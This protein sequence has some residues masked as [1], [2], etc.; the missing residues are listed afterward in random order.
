MSQYVTNPQ[1]QIDPNSTYQM[2]ADMGQINA[3]IGVIISS[4]ISVVMFGAGV[5]YLSKGGSFKV[6][7]DQEIQSEITSKECQIDP[8]TKANKCQYHLRYNYNG[9]IY[10]SIQQEQDI[11]IDYKTGDIVKLY[12]DPQS[13]QIAQA[14]H[15]K[16]QEVSD[17]KIGWVL[18]V[19][20]II[21]LVISWS[22]NGPQVNPEPLQPHM[23]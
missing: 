12:I 3:L 17:K 4:I 16:Y 14:T 20:S 1:P 13:P 18:I 8:L 21:I 2:M 22:I 5:Y 10:Y 15:G 6:Y 7:K 23:K 11:G 9:T 19:L